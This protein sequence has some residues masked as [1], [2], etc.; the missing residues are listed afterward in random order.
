MV[1]TRSQAREAADR[2]EALTPPST[3]RTSSPK[4]QASRPTR[5]VETPPVSARRN[6]NL[7]E[8]RGPHPRTPLGVL[9]SVAGAVGSTVWNG[10]FNNQETQPQASD[11]PNTQ[12]A[13]AAQ[14]S[15]ERIVQQLA[16]QV[17]SLSAQ[18]ARMQFSGSS[19]QPPSVL[20]PQLPSPHATLPHE[21]IL[22]QSHVP[23]QQ[24][25]FREHRQPGPSDTAST[26]PTLPNSEIG[27][28]NCKINIRKFNIKHSLIPLLLGN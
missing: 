4:S 8:I 24:R 27:D 18:V 25:Q 22:E 20:Q 26:R 7:E 23:Q 15:L 3:P 5:Q 9:G 11:F 28:S 14:N 19:C 12:A 17:S 10:F 21:R 13:A 6:S 16:T 2:G 1:V